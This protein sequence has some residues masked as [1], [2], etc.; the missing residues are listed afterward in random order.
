MMHATKVHNFG[1]FEK[2]YLVCNENILLTLPCI[3]FLKLSHTHVQILLASLFCMSYVEKH[4][5]YSHSWMKLSFVKRKC[6]N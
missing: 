2:M 5:L 3:Y 4:Y 6:Y 1:L